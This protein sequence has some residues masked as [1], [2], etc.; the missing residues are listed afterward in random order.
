MRRLDRRTFLRG[1]HGVALGLPFLSAM[2]PRRASAQS[3]APRRVIFH[4]KPNGDQIDRRFNGRGETRFALGEFLEPLEPYRN[5]LLFI[6]GVDKRYDRL[7]YVERA[8]NHQQGGSGLAPWPSGEGSFP[9][10]GADRFVGYVLGPSADFALGQRTLDETPGL[11]HRHLVMR[12]G[13][14]DNTIWNQHSHAGPV[15]SQAPIPPIVDPFRAYAEL[16]NGLG[17]PGAGARVQRT[18][19][20]KRSALDL[21]MGELN[22]L[23]SRLGSEDKQKLERHADALSDIE[24]TLRT[25]NQAGG[26]SPLSIPT[27]ADVFLDDQHEAV[28][29]LFYR[30]IALAFACDLTRV[31]QFNWSG[32]TSNRVYRNLGLTIG[33]HDI[34]HDL[35]GFIHIRR[36]HR[37]LWARTT[38]LYEILKNTP[39]GEGTLWDHTMIFHWNELGEGYSH[40]IRDLLVVLAGGAH[41]YFRGGRLLDVHQQRVNSF[42]DALV[43]VFHYMGYEDVRRFGDPRLGSGEPIANVV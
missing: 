12:V 17:D 19:R 11:P 41:G 31:V 2:L 28:G 30:I 37:H 25:L 21:V 23:S 38:E 18:L 35:N 3:A 43:N 7:D 10:G 39:D 5:D 24:R 26:C 40:T 16:F 22:G 6:D 13:D 20:M 8:D 34:S 32:N 27:R 42:S 29:R 1:A 9:V 4:F 14:N 36:I 15:G 33:H